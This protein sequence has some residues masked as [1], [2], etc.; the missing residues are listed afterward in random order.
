MKSQDS[1]ERIWDE[2]PSHLP[3]HPLPEGMEDRFW[4][5]FSEE[6]GGEEE[7]RQRRAARMMWWKALFQPRWMGAAFGAAAV[8]LLMLTSFPSEIVRPERKTASTAQIHPINSPSPSDSPRLYQNMMLYENIEVLEKMK[9][10]EQLPALT[11][12]S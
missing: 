3:E 12:G 6:L 10:L 2:L 9:L 1:F 5:R 8:V 7:R 11:K 4:Q